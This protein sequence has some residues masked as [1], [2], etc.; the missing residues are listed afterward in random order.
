MHSWQTRLL[1]F[2]D[3]APLYNRIQMDAPWDDPLNRGNA[4]VLVP[5]YL[6]P[7]LGPPAPDAQGLGPSHYTGNSLV[8]LQNNS[9]KFREVTDGLSNT[10]LAGQAGGGFKPW[11]DPTNVRDPGLGLGTGPDRFGSTDRAGVQLLLLDG[12]VRV[13]N[14]SISPDVLKAMSTPNGGEVVPEF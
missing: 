10:I 5:V 3:Q 14:P 9:L 11:A 7:N 8:L 12:S 13:V 2:V 1:P 6:D 4:S